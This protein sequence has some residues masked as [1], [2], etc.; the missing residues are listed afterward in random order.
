[1][2]N[3]GGNTREKAGFCGVNGGDCW[4]RCSIP[5]KAVRF[6]T[7]SKRRESGPAREGTGRGFMR[8]GFGA[9]GPESDAGGAQAAG[10]GPFEV[11]D[12]LAGYGGDGVEL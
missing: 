1:M 12:A 7:G 11:F 2:P 9:M 3:E 5:E 6:R 10:E 8:G 4:K